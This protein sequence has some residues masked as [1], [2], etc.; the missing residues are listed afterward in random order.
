MQDI[1]K[2]F[3][4]IDLKAEHYE[5]RPPA[6]MNRLLE[7]LS[8][9]QT[10][11]IQ[12]YRME[13]WAYPQY[14]TKIHVFKMGLILIS[15]LRIP[16]VQIQPMLLRTHSVEQVRRIKRSQVQRGSPILGSCARTAMTAVT[17]IQ[18]PRG[19]E[20]AIQVTTSQVS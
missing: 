11:E 4:D 13:K 12:Y 5:T 9:D 18:I 8:D 15:F 6:H 19:A 10:K 2:E 14:A 3:K 20:V 1:Q 7:N 16:R 17:K